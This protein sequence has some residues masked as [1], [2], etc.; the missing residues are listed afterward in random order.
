[1][2]RRTFLALLAA[3]PITSFVV[4]AEQDSGDNPLWFRRNFEPID[5]QNSLLGIYAMAM[6][7]PN[8]SAATDVIDQLSTV[9]FLQRSGTP[10]AH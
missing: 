5:P 8:E 9:G 2:Q 4:K 10:A 7:F 6:V 1:M 3:L